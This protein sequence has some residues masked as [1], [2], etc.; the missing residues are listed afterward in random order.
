MTIPSNERSAAPVAARRGGALPA[1]A[2]GAAIGMVAGQAIESAS[3]GAD[4]TFAGA[5]GGALGAALGRS[6]WI[7]VSA[8][9]TRGR[10]AALA[11][12]VLVG[13]IAGCA[14]VGLGFVAS[15]GGARANAVPL[16][17]TQQLAAIIAGFALL[18]ATAVAEHRWLRGPRLATTSSTGDTPR[19]D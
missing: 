8:A 14:L 18:V 19:G 13:R 16:Q 10:S 17:G 3:G 7:R 11:I 5:I 2:I 4:P 12:A 1:M 9:R 15:L 6:G